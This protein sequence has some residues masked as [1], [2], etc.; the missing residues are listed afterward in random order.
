[1]ARL[2]KIK[3]YE[4]LRKDTING[5]VINIDTSAYEQHQKMKEQV[6]LRQAEQRASQQTITRMQ[7]EMECIKNDMT[8]IKQMLISIMNKG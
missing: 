1:M 6:L 4:K 8:D 2:E 5:G 7:S 3:G